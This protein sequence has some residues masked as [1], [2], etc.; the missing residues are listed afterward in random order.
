MMGFT[1]IEAEVYLLAMQ[2]L[3]DWYISLT[4]RIELRG[5]AATISW[6]IDKFSAVLIINY[7]VSPTVFFWVDPPLGLDNGEL[8]FQGMCFKMFLQHNSYSGAAPLKLRSHVGKLISDI[9]WLENE[10]IQL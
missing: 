9:C 7:R 1:L 3:I 2:L 10:H 8:Y 4:D 6:L 5:R